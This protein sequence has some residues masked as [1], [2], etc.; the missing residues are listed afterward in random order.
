MPNTTDRSERLPI[1]QE[2]RDELITA[3]HKQEANRDAAARVRSWLSHRM[4]ATVI[5]VAFVLA[6]GAIAA[7]ATG[8][9]MEAL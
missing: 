1:L 8:V 7:A 6:G 2:I 9:L 3:A 5:A 4:N